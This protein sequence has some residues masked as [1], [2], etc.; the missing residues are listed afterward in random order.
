MRVQEEG[1]ALW[2][3]LSNWATNSVTSTDL[4]NILVE[5]G[6]TKTSV[7]LNSIDVL[8]ATAIKPQGATVVKCA[9]DR[10]I[11]KAVETAARVGSANV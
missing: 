9:R 7:K 1:L 8:G 11:S 6:A 2:T 10:G 5:L 3:S 4:M